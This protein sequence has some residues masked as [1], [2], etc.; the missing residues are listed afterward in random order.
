MSHCSGGEGAFDID[1][2]TAM[3]EWREKGKTPETLLAT[4]PDVIPGAFGAPPSTGNGFTQ[5][6]C[7]YPNVARYKGSGDDKD[8]AN[9]ECVAP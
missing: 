1:W 2:L 7:V 9:F 6:A 5:P 3:E 8:A 4:R